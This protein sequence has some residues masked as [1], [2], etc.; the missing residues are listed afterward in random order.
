MSRIFFLLTIVAVMALSMS[1]EDEQANGVDSNVIDLIGFD[2]YPT[3]KGKFIEYEVDSTLVYNQD[4]KTI[5]ETGI[6]SFAREEIGDVFIKDNQEKA[7]EILRFYKKNIEDAWLPESTWQVTYTD[8]S[9]DRS[10]E[11]LRLIN[12]A[13]PIS[14]KKFWT[15]TSFIQEDLDY[16][17]TDKVAEVMQIYKGWTTFYNNINEPLS[18]N[19]FSFPKTIKVVQV[20][21]SND[22]NPFETRVASEIYAEGIGLVQR[23]MHIYDTQCQSCCQISGV[24]TSDVV[25]GP[26]SITID[27][28]KCLA[29]K[30]NPNGDGP[31][32]TA[33]KGYSIVQ[34]VINHNY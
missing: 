7:F 30:Q 18:V 20:D 33:E 28:A 3:E 23:E 14:S 24:D 22:G 27:Q 31:L 12:L 21:N 29:L 26:S 25:N 13:F 17:Y 15:S 16:L 8:E 32:E 11:N 4:A 2:F 1:C 10:E 9:V 19:G 34:T 5:I 6:K